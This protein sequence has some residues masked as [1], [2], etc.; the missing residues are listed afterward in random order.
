MDQLE[1]FYAILRRLP[2]PQSGSVTV[3]E[4]WA[5]SGVYQ[6]LR[7]LMA[8]D[9]WKTTWAEAKDYRKGLR[10]ESETS[11]LAKGFVLYERHFRFQRALWSKETGF[12][13]ARERRRRAKDPDGYKARAT[14]RQRRRRARLKAERVTTEPSDT[15]SIERVY[16]DVA[17]E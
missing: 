2:G 12:N 15:V 6:G 5:L 8:P 16:M 7:S 11:E 14:E 10:T 3:K 13:A 4:W 1:G 17:A 9:V